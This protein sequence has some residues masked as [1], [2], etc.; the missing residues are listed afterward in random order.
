VAASP[1]ASAGSAGGEEQASASRC[2]TV[3]YDGR[4]FILYYRGLSCRSARRKVR[5]VHNNERLRG[6]ACSS[7]SGFRTGGYCQRTRRKYFGWH[8]GD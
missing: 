5:R 2:G 1:P 3:R 4:T 6:W 8:P 7:G